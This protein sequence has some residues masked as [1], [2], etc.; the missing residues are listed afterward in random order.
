MKAG[1]NV[2]AKA[3]QLQR[4]QNKTKE[5]REKQTSRTPTYAD[6]P[7]KNGVTLTSLL[8]TENRIHHIISTITLTAKRSANRKLYRLIQWLE[9]SQ[10]PDSYFQKPTSKSLDDTAVASRNHDLLDLP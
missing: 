3:G 2:E 4:S 8:F 9:V 1:E 6:C 10:K 5:T 7:S